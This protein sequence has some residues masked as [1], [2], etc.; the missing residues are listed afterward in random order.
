MHIDTL[1][2][3]IKR[4]TECLS[5]TLTTYQ[6]N[7]NIL[8]NSIVKLHQEARVAK[9][10]KTSDALRNLLNSAGIIIIQGTAG[11]EYKDI[12]EALRG[13]PVGDTWRLK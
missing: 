4:T 1:I 12:P 6:R 11:Y 9:D 3:D 5:Q 8:I 13:R 7:H 10:Y 2:D